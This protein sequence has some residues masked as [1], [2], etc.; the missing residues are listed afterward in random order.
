ML[1]NLTGSKSFGRRVDA[2]ED[3]IGLLDGF[4]DLRREELDIKIETF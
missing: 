1:G 3:E 2:D 4:R